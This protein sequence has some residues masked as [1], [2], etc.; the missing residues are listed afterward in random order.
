MHPFRDTLRWIAAKFVMTLSI[1]L[2]CTQQWNNG[3]KRIVRV[4][5]DKIRYAEQ[6]NKITV[7][8]IIFFSATASRTRTTGGPHR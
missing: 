6:T 7:F 1:A 2:S 3:S 4:R 8:P 5:S